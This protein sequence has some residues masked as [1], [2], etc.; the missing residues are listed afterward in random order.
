MHDYT[1]R[2]K[3]ATWF[4]SLGKE[5]EHILIC[6]DD[7]YFYLTNSVNKPNNGIWPDAQHFKSKET[8]L[9]DEKVLLC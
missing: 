8:P 6:W 9:N 2:V 1:S 7:A 3:F 4:V 5:V